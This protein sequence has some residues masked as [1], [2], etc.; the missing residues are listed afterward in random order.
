[1]FYGYVGVIGLALW[2]MLKWWFKSGVALAQ[3]WCIYGALSPD[4]DTL[5]WTLMLH[6]CWRSVRHWL[7]SALP[8]VV[9]MFLV[10]IGGLRCTGMRG[11]GLVQSKDRNDRIWP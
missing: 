3:V 9:L 5:G 8:G 10:G 4:I 1:M 11:H 7:V 6:G 2:A